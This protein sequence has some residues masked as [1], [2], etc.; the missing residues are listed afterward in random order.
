MIDIASME[1]CMLTQHNALPFFSSAESDVT[2]YTH[3]FLEEEELREAELAPEPERTTHISCENYIW[4]YFILVHGIDEYLNLTKKFKFESELRYSLIDR[5]NKEKTLLKA[6]KWKASEITRDLGSMQPITRTTF[7][8]L[9]FLR[10]LNIAMT[11]G[12]V[13][14]I[15]KNG[16]TNDYYLIKG[17]TLWVDPVERTTVE[18]DYYIV[19]KLDKPFK[20]MTAYKL[21]ELRE[22]CIQMKILGKDD[23]VSY[24][25]KELYQKMQESVCDNE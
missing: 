2:I 14:S 19:D 1:N 21:A 11:R 15:H 10:G 12:S 13:A 8:A 6:N 4:Y 9:C 18:K 23:A 3:R 20:A 7:F 16:D 24:K 25:K 17:D 22:M 5:V